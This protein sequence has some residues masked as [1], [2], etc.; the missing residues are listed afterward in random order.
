MYQ[1]KNS[2]KQAGTSHWNKLGLMYLP[3]AHM[4][5]THLASIRPNMQEAPERLKKT[6]SL[7]VMWGLLAMF[8]TR[9]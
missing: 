8:T 7:C 9:K 5:V 2:V 6:R 1:H 4:K 3:P